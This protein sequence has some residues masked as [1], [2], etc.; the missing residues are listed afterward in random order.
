MSALLPSHLFLEFPIVICT[1]HPVA[2]NVAFRLADLA[3]AAVCYLVV[4]VAEGTVAS[5][6]A[7]YSVR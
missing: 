5:A 6:W 7:V 1:F 3:T 4:L 2:P